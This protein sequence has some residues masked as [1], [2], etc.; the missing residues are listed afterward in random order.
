MTSPAPTPRFP[1]AALTKRIKRHVVG[2]IRD[3]F[4]AT[5]PGFEPLC[6][7]EMTA[8]PIGV[9]DAEIVPGGI[10]FRGR[11]PDCWQANLHLRTANR[12][13]MRLGTFQASHFSLLEKRLSEFPWELYLPPEAPVRCRISA[14]HCRLYHKIAIAERFRRSIDRRFGRDATDTPPDDKEMTQQ[15]FIR[16]R[17]D[18]WTVSIDSSGDLLY[19]RGIKIQG[20]TAP[21]RET[22]A[23]AALIAAGY[24]GRE[25]L[26]DPM[27]GTGTF[28]LEAALIATGM[29]PGRQRQF[30]FMQWPSFLPRR[31]THMVKASETIPSRPTRP[32]IFASDRDAEVCDALRQ[33]V[34]PAGL[35]GFI[36][37]T[38]RDFFEFGASNLISGRW[39]KMGDGSEGEKGL[40]ALNPPYGRRIGTPE[41]SAVLIRRICMHLI[42]EYTGWRVV[43][44]LPE[45]ELSRLVPFKTRSLPFVN[46][47][48]QMVILTGNI[49]E[50]EG[51][52]H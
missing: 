41:E 28:S 44:V 38:H 25:P 13:L 20:G 9:R 31:W 14:H 42:A 34:T 26:I 30:A 48:L 4:V 50:H 47:G 3:Y 29:A 21:I 12:I 16:G 40:I 5:T 19:K 22:I 33:G 37:I 2:R 32:L 35:D 39:D 10:A 51:R 11:L 23:A 52:P 49:P 27:C 1:Q 24:S 15:L 17:D 8:A 46:G 6:L 36:Q 43:L 7:N 45:G 18:R